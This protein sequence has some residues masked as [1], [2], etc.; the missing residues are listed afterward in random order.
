MAF[1]ERRARVLS[2]LVVLL[3]LVAVLQPTIGSPT[4]R[5]AEAGASSSADQVQLA[6]SPAGQTGSDEPSRVV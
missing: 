3:V 6:A 1:S 4:V 2:L 5:A